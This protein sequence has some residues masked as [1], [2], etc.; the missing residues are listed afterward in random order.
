MLFILPFKHLVWNR[1][2]DSIYRNQ[3][4]GALTTFLVNFEGLNKVLHRCYVANVLR[5]ITVVWHAAWQ[6]LQ[7]FKLLGHGLRRLL[8]QATGRPYCIHEL[9]VFNLSIKVKSGRVFMWN[10]FWLLTHPL[11]LW[12]QIVVRLINRQVLVMAVIKESSL[13][14]RVMVPKIGAFSFKHLR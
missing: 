11:H 4:A 8:V 10:F 12:E 13:C 6:L 14:F 7:A 1:V 9:C 2:L 3:I 5:V